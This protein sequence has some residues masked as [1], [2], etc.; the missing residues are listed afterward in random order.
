MILMYSRA[1][2]L[3]VGRWLLATCGS[4]GDVVHVL[5]VL[6]SISILSIH[7]KHCTL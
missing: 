1:H 3:M 7:A 6:T 5:A 4:V 2:V